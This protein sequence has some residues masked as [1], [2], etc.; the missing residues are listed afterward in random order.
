MEIYPSIKVELLHAS[1]AE[2]TWF[3]LNK[4]LHYWATQLGNYLCYCLD[5]IIGDSSLF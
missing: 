5:K 3:S 4:V 2:K 1:E